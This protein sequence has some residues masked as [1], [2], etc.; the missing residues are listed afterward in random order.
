MSLITEYVDEVKRLIDSI[1][2]KLSTKIHVDNRGEVAL[3]LK[4]EI[5]FSDRSELH[6]K[7][8][9]IAI[10]VLRKVAYSYHYQDRDKKIIF[11]F[12][13]AEHHLEIRTYPYHKHIK[14]TIVPSNEISLNEVIKNIIGMQS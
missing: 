7:E 10:P 6:Y 2:F 4:G 13:N 14:G 1:P 12:D 9:F 5:I 8:Y 11:R 3:Y